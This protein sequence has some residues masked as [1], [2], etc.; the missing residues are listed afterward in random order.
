MNRKKHLTPEQRYVIERERETGKSMTAI[1]YMIGVHPSTVSREIRRNGSLKGIYHAESAEKD[2]SMRKK[3]SHVWTS[4]SAT[5]WNGVET[6][7]QEGHSPEQISDR[8]KKSLGTM[9]SHESIYTYI[10]R[11]A[12]LGGTLY[13]HLRR[14]RKKRRS[15]FPKALDQRGQIKNRI[16]IEER[17]EIVDDR[18]RVGDWEVDTIISRSSKSALVTA[19][20]RCSLATKIIKV[21]CREA[22]VVTVALSQSLSPFKKSVLTITGDNGKEFAGHEE[23][24]SNLNADFYFA[25]PY[26]SWERGT[27]ENTNGLIRQYFPKKTNFS[28][29]SEHDVALVEWKINNRPRKSLG[30]RTAAEV[31][32]ETTGKNIC[33]IKIDGKS[34]KELYHKNNFA[35]AT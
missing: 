35:L 32:Y 11:D 5:T 33:T 19:V 15:R 24:G 29:V 3:K 6:C 18:S 21:D 25:R 10:A 4:I 1:S 12:K 7:I 26:C 27:N 8:I 13:T 23:I 20:D 28:K 9:I 31:F 34:A 2:A 17:P 30:Y 14:R 16:G 22:P